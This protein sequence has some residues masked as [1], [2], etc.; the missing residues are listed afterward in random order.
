MEVTKLKT[1]KSLFIII[2]KLSSKVYLYFNT[3]IHHCLQLL[4]LT[5]TLLGY[6]LLGVKIDNGVVPRPR[7]RRQG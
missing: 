4:Y 7:V 2:L 6:R 3:S 5:L 1:L